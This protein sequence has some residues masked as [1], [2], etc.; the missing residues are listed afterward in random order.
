MYLHEVF[1][2]YRRTA[3]T[4]RWLPSF[5][6]RFSNE[7]AEQVADLCQRD[8]NDVFHDQNEVL[9]GMS[10][11]DSIARGL[12]A[13]RCLVALLSPTYF[14]SPHCLVEWDTFKLRGQREGRDLVVPVIIR[15][16]A[17]V[18]QR[19]GDTM[20]ADFSPYLIDG[21]AFKNTE[22]YVEFQYAI[23]R[24]AER[25]GH[26]IAQAPAWQ[27]TPICDPPITP[28]LQPDPIPLVGLK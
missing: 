5:I 17:T 22:C 13:S 8:A 16:G 15:D 7:L 23:Q 27:D 2:S 14:R 9:P 3:L 20:A 26:I 4:V 25:V 10:I 18:R 24:L 21:A 28:I 6:P 12:K 19:I 1:L 11:P